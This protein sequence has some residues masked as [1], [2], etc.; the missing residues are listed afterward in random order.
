MGTT[1]RPLPTTVERLSALF[2]SDRR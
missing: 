1:P 2:L